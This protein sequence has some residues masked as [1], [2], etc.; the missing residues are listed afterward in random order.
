M[1]H[2]SPGLR[3][4]EPYPF[5]ELDRRKSEAVDAGP[6]G[7]STSVSATRA[8]R[9]R[10]S[11]ATRSRT[12]SGRSR[13]T[14]GPPGCPALRRAIAGW[15]ER[16]FGVDARPRH[17]DPA[18]P[19]VEGA[20]V[21]ARAGRARSRR[22]ARTWCSR[23]RP[24]Y[25]IPERGARV[26]RRRRPRACRCTEERG[27]LPDLDAVTDDAWERAVA[28][29]AQLPE[30][31]DRARS[32]RCRSSTRRPSDAGR[33]TCCSPPT[34]PTASS[35]SATAPPPSALAAGGPDERRSSSTR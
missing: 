22:R 29:V 6:H 13:R 20:R 4:V 34:R 11:S 16:R 8:R 21:L 14:R 26:R 1:V 25:P 23:P 27:F 2:L 33:T 5:E 9:R 15:V 7:R 30:Q 31:P 17:R 35:G 10:R 19:R 24:G 3:A 12:R 28:P 32:R 18:D